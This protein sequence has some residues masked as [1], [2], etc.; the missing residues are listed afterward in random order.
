MLIFIINLLTNFKNSDII[1]NDNR[2]EIGGAEMAE[3]VK[4]EP[5]NLIR[6]MPA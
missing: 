4:T 3:M 6:I 5:F 1:P 2:I